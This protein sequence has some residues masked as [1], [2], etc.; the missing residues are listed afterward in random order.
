MGVVIVALLVILWAWVL[1]PGAV[2]ERRATTPRATVA[3]FQ[4]SMR[5]LGRTGAWG[6]AQGVT[7][8]AVLVPACAPA[9]QGAQV[10]ARR[11]RWVLRGL[12]TVVLLAAL[13]ARA[14][15]GAATAVMWTATSV[16]VGYCA[17]VGVVWWRR[18]R[19]EGVPVLRTPLAPAP[20]V[21]RVERWRADRA[22]D[23]EE[24]TR[25]EAEQV[26]LVEW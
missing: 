8:R 7:G 1:L 2:R 24:V 21:A 3:R 25:V 4:R 5:R 22:A 11:Q 19:E 16:L 23:G 20:L 10:M 12:S 13:A 17:A 6:P 26:R 14:W 18:C 9:T 15:G